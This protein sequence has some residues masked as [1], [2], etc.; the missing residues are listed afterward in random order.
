MKKNRISIAFSY[1]AMICAITIFLLSTITARAED[2]CTSES[3]FIE[4][5][6]RQA[7]FD[8]LDCSPLTGNDQLIVGAVSDSEYDHWIDYDE[9]EQR[10]MRIEYEAIVAGILS[11]IKDTWTD[12]E[13]VFYLHDYITSHAE[14]ALNENGCPSNDSIHYSAYGNL[15]L[16]ESV[17]D[18]Y[19]RAFYDLANRVGV[20][21]YVVVSDNLNHA[22]NMVTLNGKHYYIDCT[23]DGQESGNDALHTYFLKSEDYM[24]EHSHDAEDWCINAYWNTGTKTENIF[25]KYNDKEYDNAVWNRVEHPIAFRDGYMLYSRGRIYKYTGDPN[26]SEELIWLDEYGFNSQIVSVNGKTFVNSINKIY[27]YDEE[28]NSLTELYEMPESQYSNFLDDI[29]IEGSKL[30]YSVIN[31]YALQFV[32]D[33]FIDVEEYIGKGDASSI[34]FDKKYEILYKIGDEFSIKASVNPSAYEVDKWESTDPDVATVDNK[35]TV[36]VVGYGYTYIKAYC[37][38]KQAWCC[39]VVPNL[40]PAEDVIN[41]NLSEG[42]AYKAV[43]V[44]MP[45]EQDFFPYETL[46]WKSSNENIANPYNEK[47]TIYSKRNYSFRASGIDC[48]VEAE[49]LF[50]NI[51]K[52][53]DPGSAEITISTEDGKLSAVIKVNVIRPVTS[54]SLQNFKSRLSVGEQHQFSCEYSPEEA[55]GDTTPVWSSSDTSVATIDSN[56]TVTGISEGKAVITVTIQDKS[57][58]TE[59]EIYEGRVTMLRLYNPNSGEHFYTSSEREK[60]KLVKAGWNYEGIAWEG[61]E[62]SNTPVYRLYNPNVGEHHYTPSKKERDK[63]VKLGWNDEGIG[64]YSDDNKG[65][66]LYRLYNPNATTGNH[67]YTTSTKERDKLVKIGWNDEGIGWYAYK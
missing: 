57:A 55:T 65:T 27:L 41:I 59:I 62:K 48:F 53:S 60:N 16:H 15:V 30:Y 44:G 18:G 29:Y 24:Y 64:W 12:E 1:A 54:V 3:D 6:R 61:P 52:V 33:G 38:N 47:S 14:Y 58:S 5:S 28:H 23:W 26:T 67:H 2:I 51:I 20:E 13:K 21:T 40:S 7:V 42:P 43:V 11:E 32:R 36:K 63:L 35:G 34:S 46:I 17:C 50:E 39:V 31:N 66:P 25:G 22:W 56:G 19:S 37:G 8:P 4:E 10:C 45:K 9:D 49:G